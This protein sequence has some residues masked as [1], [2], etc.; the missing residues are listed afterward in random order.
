MTAV[1]WEEKSVFAT[2]VTLLHEKVNKHIYL[3][4]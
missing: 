3:D 4:T 1:V 2:R